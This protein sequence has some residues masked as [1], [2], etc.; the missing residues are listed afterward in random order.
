[1]EK[2]KRKQKL[3]EEE[4]KK[5]GRVAVA[6][7]SG[8]DS[9]FLLKTAHDLLGENAVAITAK[10]PCFM[11]SETK[12]AEEFCKKE[13]IKQIVLEFNP[14]EV[15]QFR[16]NA[17]DRCYFCK[18]ALFSEI[19]RIAKENGISHILDGTN[20]DDTADY[21][22]GMEALEELG[23]ISPLLDAGLTKSNIRALSEELDLPTFNKPSYACLASRIA[24]GEEITKEKLR[25]VEN[26]EQKLFDMGFEQFRVRV[27]GKLARIELK[28]E[29]IPS[30][31]NSN[32]YEQAV[33]YFKTL[34]FS[35]V[36]LD[37]EGFK[38]GSMNREI[39][40]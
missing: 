30:F 21:R 23:I 5:L 33:L 40:K 26:A 31:I 37:L 3:L 25:S 35:F 11:K 39:L 32:Q 4:L 36:S 27:H 19:K 24:Y 2:L 38:S 15:E 16:S 6:F 18:K 14:L 10:A 22:P 7:S 29:D 8:V 17:P 1:M 9:T 28:K 34:G 20:A 12:Q 13:G